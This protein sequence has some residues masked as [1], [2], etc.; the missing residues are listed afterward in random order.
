LATPIDGTL[1]PISAKIL[2]DD[3]SKT[4]AKP[5]AEILFHSNLDRIGDR[6]GD[7]LANDDSDDGI[8]FGRDSPIFHGA[9]GKSAPLADPC[10]SREQ[11]RIAYFPAMEAF[12]VSPSASSRRPVLAFTL[13][14]DRLPIDQPLKPGSLVAIGDRVLLHL[15]TRPPQSKMDALGLVGDSAEMNTLRQRIRTVSL[16]NGTALIYGESGVGKELVA[17]AIHR[18]SKN[19]DSPH[20]VV[21]CAAIP[22]NLLESNLF[23]HIQGAFTGAK[24][25][26]EGLF[27][28]AGRGSVFLDE[29]GELP[30][31]MQSKLLRVL[32]ERKVCPVGGHRETP[33]EARMIA[34]TNR[35]LLEEVQAGRFREDL[36][37]RLSGLSIDVPP[38]R[39]H[40]EDIALLFKAFFG[41][42]RDEHTE[43]RRWW[44]SADQHAPPIPME[45]FQGMLAFDWP[46][47]VRQLRNSIES[48]AV[49]NVASTEFVYPRDFG[50]ASPSASSNAHSEEMAPPADSSHET[51]GSDLDEATLLRLLEKHDYVQRRVAKELGVSHTTIDR[52]MREMG[53]R[54]PR[55]FAEEELQEAAVKAGQNLNVMARLLRVSRRGLQL[56]LSALGIELDTD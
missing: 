20:L 43:L 54:R 26:K 13:H 56:R 40:P 15:T 33:I 25:D 4:A 22:E 7:A 55:D 17:R 9:D 45:L 11:L 29:I 23:G 30:L 39:E 28:A 37:Y 21:N 51:T 1:D 42:K 34:A 27:K 52:R 5:L 10:I 47:N 16:S 41:E 8:I 6:I 50:A 36:Y 32:Q 31:T 3:E 46:G 12:R 48:L 19:R 53:F 24:T 35:N 18:A 2:P 49:E 38:L 14:G 44:R